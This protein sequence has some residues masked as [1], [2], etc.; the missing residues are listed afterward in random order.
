MKMKMKKQKCP[1]E[2]GLLGVQMTAPKAVYVSKNRLFERDQYSDKEFTAAELIETELDG[3]CYDRGSL[4]TAQAQAENC[5]KAMG[6]LVQV[7]FDRGAIS[8]CDVW[9]VAGRGYMTD[10]R[11]WKC[12][13]NCE[14]GLGAVCEH[15]GQEQ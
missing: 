8:R 15:C 9:E 14:R 5:S 7:L 1:M 6:R 3:S 13:E 12:S 2:I 4:E 11:C 10:D